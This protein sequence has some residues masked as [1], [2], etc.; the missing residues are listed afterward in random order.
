MEVKDAG[1]LTDF[2][3]RV[4]AECYRLGIMVDIAHL[5]PAGVEDVLQMADGPV[6]D[7]H[8]NAFSICQHPRNLTDAQL[9]GVA[10]SGGVVCVTYVPQFVSNHVEDASL[11]GVLDHVDYIV[12]R[13]WRRSCGIGFGF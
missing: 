4:V 8:A 12:N 9:D 6:I 2:G 7:T 1:G 10:G 13:Y 11:E 3:W 5:S